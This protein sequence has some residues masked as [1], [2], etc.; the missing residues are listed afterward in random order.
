[1]AQQENKDLGQLQEL[2]GQGGLK[3]NDAIYIYI[4]I[5]E[6]SYHNVHAQLITY[7]RNSPI[8]LQIKQFL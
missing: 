1:M 5:S 6:L 8:F 7:R 3:Y 2:R 4:K